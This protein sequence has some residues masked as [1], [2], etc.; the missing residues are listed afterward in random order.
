M[1]INPSW[2]LV[3]LQKNKLLHTSLYVISIDLYDNKDKN[4]HRFFGEREREK[5]RKRERER[6]RKRDK[7]K[8]R[9]TKWKLRY[10]V[11]DTSS[12]FTILYN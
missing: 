5:E 9:E 6:E 2:F 10:S 7:E 4:V 1:L 12:T 8:E 11:K 3:D